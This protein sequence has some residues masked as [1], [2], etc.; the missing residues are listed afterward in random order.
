MSDNNGLLSIPEAAELY[1]KHSTTIY[2]AIQKGQLNSVEVL[3]N[4]RRI[5]KVRKSDL[6]TLYGE[7]PVE[8]QLN[9][10]DSQ[11]NS[12]R[13]QSN[14]NRIQSNSTE[15]IRIQMKE[16][17]AEYFQDKETQL[18]KPLEEMATYRVGKLEAEKQFMEDRII[19]LLEENEGLKMQIKALPGPVEEVT[20]KLEILEKK[21][22]ELDQVKAEKGELAIRLKEEEANYLATIEELKKQLEEERSKPW[23]KRFF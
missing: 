10:I 17:I 3:L 18:M 8:E 12:N 4:S 13:I 5:K 15:S 11:V 2:K 21:S 23:W 16:V 22:E 1:N 7:Q 6:V 9:S 20:E 19:T 14:S